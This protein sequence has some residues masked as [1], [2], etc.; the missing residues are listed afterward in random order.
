MGY[1]HTFLHRCVFYFSKLQRQS[2]SLGEQ[3]KAWPSF[4]KSQS[5]TENN[6]QFREAS[7]Q[8]AQSCK[9]FQDYNAGREWLERCR[10]FHHSGPWGESLVL[11]IGF[12]S[13]VIRAVCP[14]LAQRGISSFSAKQTRT[15][16]FNTSVMA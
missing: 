15:H 1:I 16:L 3:F 10:L 13:H 14:V 6:L 5:M 11:L 9:P 4:L 2:L 7:G 12:H 8:A